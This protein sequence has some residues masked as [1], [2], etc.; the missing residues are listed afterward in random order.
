MNELQLA[1]ETVYD[2]LR[3]LAHHKVSQGE[4]SV[5]GSD[6]VH[7]VFLRLSRED[8][9]DAE[10]WK[11]RRFFFTAAAEAMRR[12]LVDR[13]RARK[14][15]KRGGKYDRMD[16]SISKICAKE[17]VTDFEALGEALA[18]LRT[19]HPE[20]AELVDLKFFAGLQWQEIAEIVGE[21]TR[22]IRRRWAF[23]RAWL[24]DALGR[25]V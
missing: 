8:G 23:A 10:K 5:D 18:R 24:R 1:F 13:D 14:R 3:R 7:E 22:T 17:E 9:S 19:V 15:I 4:H 21:S 16:L 6:L 25:E 12:I 20:E 2:E 11:E